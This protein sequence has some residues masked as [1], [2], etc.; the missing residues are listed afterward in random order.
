MNNDERKD[1]KLGL[2]EQGLYCQGCEKCLPQCP[3]KLPIPDLM[4]SYM[5]TY[6]YKDLGKAKDTLVSLDLPESLCSNC[7]ECLI[8]CAK[9]FD[10]AGKIND[11]I[12]VRNIPDEFLV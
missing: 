3:Q 4:R 2:N 7:N 11:V 12:R 10:I 8:H 5:Y 6:G 9:G 1:L